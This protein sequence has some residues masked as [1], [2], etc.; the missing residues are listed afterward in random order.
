MSAVGEIFFQWILFDSNNFDI[1][2]WSCASFTHNFLEG[3]SR[4][5][6]NQIGLSQYKVWAFGEILAS[7]NFIVCGIHLYFFFVCL[8]VDLVLWHLPGDHVMPL[9]P[10]VS[11]KFYCS[12]NTNLCNKRWSVINFMNYPHSWAHSGGNIGGVP[13]RQNNNKLFQDII[14]YIYVSMY[15][16]SVRLNLR[17]DERA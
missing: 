1:F 12:E 8:I 10:W 11:S 9:H 3:N 6:R 2:T 17:H 16:C 7:K 15:Q 13:V 14:G 4:D 5:W